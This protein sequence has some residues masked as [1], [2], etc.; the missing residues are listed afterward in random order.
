L[1]GPA[2]EEVHFIRDEQAEIVWAIEQTALGPAGLPTDRTA[3]ALAHFQPLTPTPNDGTAL[4]TRT[5][6][7][8]TD[9]EANWF[10]FLLQD[11]AAGSQL[12]LADVPPLDTAQSA[13]LPWGRILAPFAP[14]GLPPQPGI[15][16]P[17]EEVTR[18]GTQ[19]NRYWRY[20]RWI[21]GKHLSWVGRR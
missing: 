11:P 14:T 2:L 13:P 21:D 17:L 19:V 4:P 15:L 7:L 10:P 16:L 8:R 6:I 1:H 18:V 5:Y 9:V 20:T 3:D 12:A